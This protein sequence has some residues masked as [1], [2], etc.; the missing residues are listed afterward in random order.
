MLEIFLAHFGKIAST[1][2]VAFLIG[3]V[4]FARNVDGRLDSHERTDVAIIERLDALIEKVE[5]VKSDVSDLK[6]APQAESDRLAVIERDV[7]EVRRYLI[8]IL[9]R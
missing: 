2:L 7:K 9:N 5:D 8:Q 6:K 1:L 3:T 4:G